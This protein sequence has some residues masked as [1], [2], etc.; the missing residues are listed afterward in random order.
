MPTQPNRVET[1]QFIIVT[2]DGQARGGFD[3]LQGAEAAA[4]AFGDGTHVIDTRSGP[5]QPAVQVVEDGEMRLVGH[6][7]FDRRQGLD[8]N[9][10]EAAKRDILPAVIAFLARGANIN[11][12]GPGGG[13]ALM[14][15]VARGNQDIF[16]VVMDAGADPD[17]ADKA[18][19]TPRQLAVKKNRTAFSKR[20]E[21]F[22][23]KQK[24]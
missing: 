11:A 8:G 22:P 10:V 23:K 15:A 24:A 4:V 1:R 13:S 9:L 18:G 5:Y 12:V 19:L 17:L 16:D 6:D 2:S 14:W 3:N 7:A 21:S 20:I